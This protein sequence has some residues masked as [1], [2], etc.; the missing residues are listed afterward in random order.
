MAGVVCVTAGVSPATFFR[1]WRVSIR[2]AYFVKAAVMVSFTSSPMIAG[3]YLV[4][5]NVERLIRP[6]AGKPTV[7]ALVIGL[8][9]APTN[10]ASSAIGLVTPC[11]VR[12]PSICAV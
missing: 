11:S 2:S 7:N 5:P 4:T 3:A 12:L 8:L 1:R 10:V 9:P 6:V